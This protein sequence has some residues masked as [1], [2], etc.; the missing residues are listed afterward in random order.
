[1]GFLIFL[2]KGSSFLPGVMWAKILVLRFWH[3]GITVE[4]SLHQRELDT[5][6]GPAQRGYELESKLLI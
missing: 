1:M 6:P 3:R 5:P 2:K 4:G